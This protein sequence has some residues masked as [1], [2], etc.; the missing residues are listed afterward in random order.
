MSR[1]VKQA[2]RRTKARNY[3]TEN[4][5][6][7]FLDSSNGKD[8][9]ATAFAFFEGT[10]LKA[11]DYLR[12]PKGDKY[13]FSEVLKDPKKCALEFM[14]YET[15]PPEI[16]AALG[17][18]EMVDST[19]LV[20]AIAA[21]ET[22]RPNIWPNTKD[23]STVGPYQPQ[24]NGPGKYIIHKDYPDG[25][26][27]YFGCETEEMYSWMIEKEKAHV[28]TT[29]DDAFVLAKRVEGEH[30]RRIRDGKGAGS[31]VTIVAIE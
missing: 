3:A 15:A 23:P 31:N 7:P 5:T 17:R 28:F 10:E 21:I 8:F 27:A 14:Y 26:S 24:N 2:T 11:T 30:A 16:F 4:G 20:R 25:T 22:L 6:K 13:P 19:M 29:Y 1:K 18:P 12:A 9:F